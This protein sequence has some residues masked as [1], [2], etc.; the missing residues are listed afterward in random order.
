[1]KKTFNIILSLIMVIFSFAPAYAVDD[2][3]EIN[4]LIINGGDV[5]NEEQQNA[6][7]GG[8]FF[9]ILDN[10]ENPV[11]GAEFILKN[12]NGEALHFTIAGTE[13]KPTVNGYYGSVKT[14]EDGTLHVT[15]LLEGSY[16][17]EYKNNI[18]G[19]KPIEPLKFNVTE[20]TKRSVFKTTKDGNNKTEKN[21]SDS[22][23][24]G[25]NIDVLSSTV[26]S[27]SFEFNVLDQD[28][29]GVAGV[30]FRLY[31]AS[32]KEISMHGSVGV[33]RAGDGSG[34]KILTNSNGNLFLRGLASGSYSLEQVGEIGGFAGQNV[35]TKFSINKNE[36]TKDKATLKTAKGSL[37]LQLK[38]ANTKKDIIGGKF[39]LKNSDGD[40]ITFSGDKGVYVKS[41]SSSNT[42]LSAHNGYINIS[43]LNQG[44]YRL[45]SITPPDGYAKVEVNGL[46]VRANHEEKKEIE[47]EIANGS[48]SIS[49]KDEISKD[50]VEGYEISILDKDDKE[51]SF[52]KGDLDGDFEFSNEKTNVKLK[53]DIVGKIELK[54][55]PVGIYKIKENKSAKGYVK[56]KDTTTFSIS[57]DET[58]DVEIVAQRSNAAISFIDE[59]GIPVKNVKVSISSKSGERVF[60]GETNENG[61]LLISGVKPGEYTYRARDLESPYM[62]K[63]YEGDFKINKDG[64][65]VGL[66]DQI[67]ESNKAIIKTNNIEG[68]YFK[69]K[70]DDGTFE[71]EM[72]TDIN[73]ELVFDN[74]EDGSYTI[75]QTDGP[76]NVKLVEDKITFEIDRETKEPKEFSVNMSSY[77][78]AEED[79]EKDN[80]SNKKIY[81][82]VGIAV[83][84]IG[85]AIYAFIKI[86]SSNTEANTDSQNIEKNSKKEGTEKNNKNE[87]LEP[88]EEQPVKEN[89]FN[90]YKD[91]PSDDDKE[92]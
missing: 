76:D 42:E 82:I 4:Q 78:S 48:V 74:L 62:N 26:D 59:S 61:K 64:D 50:A 84:V 90:P 80:N 66:S 2:I 9:T 86:K 27:G 18:D 30:E 83:V 52:N 55:L 67:I 88:E 54:K 69:I 16:S 35:S 65:I 79:G 34:D 24:G 40:T 49:V 25:S 92:L 51:I 31:D 21:V 22:S 81:L 5:Q 91:T 45:E 75:V 71:N 43:G 6:K 73:G 68:A 11:Q 19:I 8:I 13:Y 77:D 39:V 89:L 7:S 29:E 57:S 15:G 1:M 17:L 32:K 53:S 37:M 38:D 87:N 46:N 41:S 58:T 63:I 56:N 70:N 44:E 60:S 23:T 72:A 85:S 14:S 47:L 36:T 20:G 3:S 10:G 12:S 28:G 33:F